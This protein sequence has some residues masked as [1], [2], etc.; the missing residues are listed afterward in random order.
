MTKVIVFENEKDNSLSICFPTGDLP[1]EEILEKD[2]PKNALIIDKQSLPEK[3]RDFYKAWRL[4]NSEVKIDL[5][6]AKEIAKER[7]RIERDVL[8]KQQDIAFQIAIENNQDTSSIIAE[9]NR[10]RNITMLVDEAISLD[11]LR[12]IHC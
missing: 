11:D 4:I 12:S 5:N 7:L 3:D 10:L 9:K 1:I 6:I 2:C 8:L